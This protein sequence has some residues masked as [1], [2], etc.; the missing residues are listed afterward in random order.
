MPP[1]PQTNTLVDLHDFYHK[2]VAPELH[3]AVSATPPHPVLIA[4]AIKF[5]SVFRGQLSRQ[6][7]EAVFPLLL[8][9]L[10]S[11]NLVVHTYAAAAIERMLTVRE[12][13]R[14]EAPYTSRCM[15]VCVHTDIYMHVCIYIHTH[16]HT[17][18]YR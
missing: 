14:C 9:L 5:V 1:P 17:S 2:H 18:I 11:P 12:T 6:T 15:C 7:Y 4:D 8:G 13:A 10:S 16:T 3:A